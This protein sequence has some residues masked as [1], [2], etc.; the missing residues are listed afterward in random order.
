MGGRKSPTVHAGVG[1]LHVGVLAGRDGNRVGTRSASY[2]RVP[3]VVEPHLPSLVT[4][5]SGRWAS[6]RN[7]LRRAPHETSCEISPR[8]VRDLLARQATTY[9]VKSLRKLRR[10]QVGHSVVR[11]G[12]E[13]KVWR[14]REGV[15]CIHPWTV[16][17]QTPGNTAEIDR[18]YVG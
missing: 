12:Y 13:G 16:I 15:K 4:G 8:E 14:R 3:P 11:D 2:E 7:A 18:G 5:V 6:G 1:I 9:W 10:R 17:V